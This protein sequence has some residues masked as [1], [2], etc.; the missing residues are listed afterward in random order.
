MSRAFKALLLACL[1]VSGSATRDL[2]GAK[3]AAASPSPAPLPAPCPALSTKD[4]AALVSTAAA[5]AQG[6]GCGGKGRG[7]RCVPPPRMPRARPEIGHRSDGRPAPC[8]LP[9]RCS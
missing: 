9:A 2:Q 1:L 6:R 4:L 8:P 3:P 7:R 5:K